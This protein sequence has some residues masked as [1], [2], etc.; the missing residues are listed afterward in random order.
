MLFAD[1]PPQYIVIR[2]TP[3]L[4]ADLSGPT[5]GS[6][7]EVG[8]DPEGNF[9]GKEGEGIDPNDVGELVGEERELGE[10]AHGQETLEN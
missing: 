1:P 8:E 5:E 9:V 10:T 2:E 3:P 4:L 6:G 7:I